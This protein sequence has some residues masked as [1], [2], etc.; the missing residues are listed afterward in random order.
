MLD[1]VKGA[2][3]GGHQVVDVDVGTDRAGALGAAQE[4]ADGRAKLGGR[5]GVGGSDVRYI[6]CSNYTA[7][8]I[9]ESQ[10]AAQRSSA[11]PFISLQAQYSLIARE[12][13]AEIAPACERH[14]L[15]LLTYSPLASGIL[16]GRYERDQPPAADSR[17]QYWLNFP[18]PAAGT[19]AR[20]ML[21]QRSFDIATC[22]QL[23]DNLAAFDLELPPELRQR[24]DDA[25]APANQPVTGMLTQAHASQR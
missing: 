23:R 8:S 18:N 5:V 7:S 2:S 24:L 1:G 15:G 11:T 4:G 6:G 3:Q 13:E 12:I 20:A 10:W 22:D 16:A 14:G 9:I 25:S 17:I 19:W 21:S